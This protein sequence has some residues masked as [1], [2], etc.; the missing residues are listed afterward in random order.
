ME[1]QTLD[2]DCDV[3]LEQIVLLDLERA[4][5]A[6]IRDRLR[7]Q[8]HQ[9]TFFCDCDGDIRIE[10]HGE[11]GL[12]GTITFHHGLSIRFERWNSDA[13]LLDGPALLRWM[14]ERGAS[15]PLHKFEQ[16][17]REQQEAERVYRAWV[18]AAPAGLDPSLFGRGFLPHNGDDPAYGQAMEA[19][20]AA[21]P[22]AEERAVVLLTW[23]AHSSSTW[24]A[25]SSY[26]SIPGELLLR[27]ES[28]TV[29]RALERREPVA[30]AT[31][32]G[33]A[34]YFS[35]LSDRK[36]ELAAVP[37]ALWERL[38]QATRR[39]G[40]EEN[41]ERLAMVHGGARGPQR[42]ARPVRDSEPAEGALPSRDHGR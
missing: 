7:I 29:L 11:A 38:L 33:A 32:L 3:W 18:E 2:P 4:E 17:E 6:T 10:L 42:G 24:S 15:G 27:V 1:I 28:G 25:Y 39:V 23:F 22:S 26:E 31:L 8:E 14:A 41:V 30:E 34:R 40:I 16:Q 20:A 12:L 36:S 37:D 35:T 9:R 19:L 5:V 21:Y 13:L